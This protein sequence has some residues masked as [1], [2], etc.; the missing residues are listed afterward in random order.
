MSDDS[1][2]RLTSPSNRRRT[3][4]RNESL[5]GPGI[6]MLGM[7][8]LAAAIAVY[9]PGQFSQR[10]SRFPWPTPPTETAPK[11]PSTESFRQAINKAMSAAELT[12][13]ATY[14]EEWVAVTQMWQEAIHLLKAVPE[15]SSQYDLAQQK[16]GEYERNLQYAQTNVTTR[17]AQSSEDVMPSWSIG[18]TRELLI[19]VQGTPSRVIRL[20]SRCEEVFYYGNSQVELKHGIV[21]SY[22][23]FDNNLK[24]SV[25]APPSPQST[26][27]WTLG[28]SRDEVFRIQGTP[29]RV[30]SFNSLDTELLHYGDNLI[31]LNHG[32]VT[33]YSDFDGRL[34]VT[35]TPL[36][37]GSPGESLPRFWQ[38]GSQ[39][40]E[41]FRVQDTP[42]QIHRD[43]SLC[44][45]VL[46]Y[47][48]STIDLQN[49]IVVG[50]DNFGNNLRVK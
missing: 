25:T 30:S 41:V 18:S 11:S 10:L 43:D 33:A 2:R 38:L 50:Y 42:T 22:D 20:D 29:T 13:S 27:D 44:R 21:A 39:R 31:E 37:A 45:E 26:T 36:F 17:P 15:T 5:A 19:A 24:A 14:R 40:A 28:S 3:A 34:K 23:N 12:Q 47:G 8:G 7:V 16:V 48:D 6:L 46:H 35:M 4:S 32:V 49:G 9:F 1:P